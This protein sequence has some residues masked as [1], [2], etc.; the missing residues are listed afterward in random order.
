V[1]N[2]NLLVS[3]SR[4]NETNAKAE[5]WF[6]LLI[7]GDEYPIISDVEYSGLIIA[8]TSLNAKDL[9]LKV[10]AIMKKD[11]NFFKYILKIVPID[12]VCETEIKIIKKII[13]NRQKDYMNHNDSFMIYLKR[14]KHENIERNSFID[15]IAKLIHNKVNLNNPNIIIRF[16]ILGNKCGIAFLKPDQIISI[17]PNKGIN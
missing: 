14:R 6:L 11:P 1:N 5:L 16:E 10:K 15:T 4:F 12:I 8:F 17:N 7:C 2:F 9:I 13:Q 3:T